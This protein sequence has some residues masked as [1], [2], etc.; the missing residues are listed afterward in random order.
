MTNFDILELDQKPTSHLSDILINLQNSC[1]KSI[2]PKYFYDE[3]GSKLFEKITNSLDYYPTK[4]E[5]E[6]L[7]KQKKLIT[8][9]FPEK[10][11]IV[12]FGSGSNKKINKFINAIRNPSEYIPIDISKEF[13]LKNAKKF[14]K[15]NPELKVTAICADFIKSNFDDIIKKK[16]KTKVGFF[17]G[18]TIGNFSP[19]KAK[20]LM[21]KISKILGRKSYLVIG[22]DLKKEKHILEKAYNDSEGITAKFNKNILQGLNNLCGSTFDLSN[23]EHEAFFN[24][25]KNR[26]EM[27]LKSNKIHKVEIMGTQILFKKGET[28]HTENSYKYSIKE[29]SKLAEASGYEI[30]K[31][32]TDDNRFFAIFCLK[33]KNL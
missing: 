7:E 23:F 27:H 25:K 8:K 16:K 31:I 15:Q 14:A 5:L 26:I 19:S 11:I 17:P 3:N 24:K 9:Y 20:T 21:K 13:L 22:V 28:I 1:Q 33:I 32:L 2:D 30:E 29:F 12:E 4:S 6:I 10:S 18:S